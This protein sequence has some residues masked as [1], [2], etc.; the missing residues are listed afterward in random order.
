ME[1]WLRDAIAPDGHI[2]S[3]YGGHW[4]ESW[5]LGYNGHAAQL[6]G[7]PPYLSGNIWNKHS[8]WV[9]K[10]LDKGAQCITPP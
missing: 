10:E 6:F 8:R 5:T 7:S 9:D 2:I 1:N 3:N 4:N